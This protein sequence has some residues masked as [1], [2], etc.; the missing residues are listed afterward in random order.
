MALYKCITDI[1]NP[2]YLWLVGVKLAS[3]NPFKIEKAVSGVSGSPQLQI[4]GG[5]WAIYSLCFGY[6]FCK[7]ENNFLRYNLNL[8]F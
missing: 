3:L 8:K 7:W 4:E 5:G 2:N 6:L 1:D